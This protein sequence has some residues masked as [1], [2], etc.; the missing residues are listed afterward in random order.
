MLLNMLSYNFR[1]KSERRNLADWILSQQQQLL[2][3]QMFNS[4]HK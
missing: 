2:K 4:S 1:E 3:Y